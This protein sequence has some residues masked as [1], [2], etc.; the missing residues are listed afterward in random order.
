MAPARRHRLP[1]QQLGISVPPEAI[2]LAVFTSSSR[3]HGS[4]TSSA[5]HPPVLSASFFLFS[6]ALLT[7][8]T[9]L[10]EIRWSL[11]AAGVPTSTYSTCRTSTTAHQLVFSTTAASVCKCV[12]GGT[13]SN[14]AF[15]QVST[16]TAARACTIFIN[17]TAN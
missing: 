6:L 17:R 8:S 3:Q 12:H 15:T 4:S 13:P 2:S 9:C 14:D 11:Q 10:D 5:A 1:S 7:L 16:S